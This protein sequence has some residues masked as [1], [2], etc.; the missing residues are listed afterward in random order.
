ME[1][2]I[3]LG[4]LYFFLGWVVFSIGHTL[5]KAFNF[6][7]SEV[8][9][10][11]S[12]NTGTFF[13]SAPHPPNLKEKEKRKKQKKLQEQ[14]KERKEKKKKSPE[15]DKVK[16]STPLEG[17]LRVP[18]LVLMKFR[19]SRVAISIPLN[20][21][22]YGALKCVQTKILNASNAFELFLNNCCTSILAKKNRISGRS[23]RCIT[24]GLRPIGYNC[25]LFN[26][27]PEALI[28]CEFL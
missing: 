20:R 16:I 14:N 19:V 5:Q 10:L 3:F 11:L 6:L 12:Y 15:K 18:T 2:K 1:K 8:G 7:Y 23:I 17:H 27:L 28:N 4:F 9:S 26:T 25:N 24:M 21:G 22:C 13:Y